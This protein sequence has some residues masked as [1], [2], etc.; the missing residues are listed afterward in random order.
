VIGQ[1]LSYTDVFK[2]NEITQQIFSMGKIA[3]KTIE[4]ITNL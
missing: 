3:L 4:F 2:Q 1:V